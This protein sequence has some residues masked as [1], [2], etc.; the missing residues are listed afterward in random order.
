M[1][2]ILFLIFALVFIS[3]ASAVQEPL[4]YYKLNLDYSYGDISTNSTEIEFSNKQ[5]GNPFG[6]YSATILDYEGNLLNS[7]L[8]DVPN[9]ILYDSV[10]E[11]GEISDGGF[12][13]L[14]E[15]SFEI[16]VP[17]Y[18]D[19]KEIVIYDENLTELTR[20]DV[21]EF[22]KEKQIVDKETIPEE[23]EKEKDVEEKS[24]ETLTNKLSQYW[25]IFVIVLIILIFYL[26]YSL[27]K[28]RY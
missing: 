28:K 24:T 21:N 26:A 11:E 12:L 19:A 22:S 1:K 3:F 27:T 4:V 2:Q 13:E 9:E 6:F 10:N 25:W 23:T 5:I 8:F 16:F 15:T 14:N 18:G 7:T 20:K 17:Y